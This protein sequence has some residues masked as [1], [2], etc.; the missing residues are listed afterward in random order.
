VIGGAAMA[1]AIGWKALK[2]VEDVE[3]SSESKE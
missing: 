3:P 1:G 2:K